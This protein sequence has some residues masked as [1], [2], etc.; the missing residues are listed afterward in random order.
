MVTAVFETNLTLQDHR[1]NIV[2]R[3]LTSWAAIIAVPT[4]VTGF[5][6]QNVEFPGE[7]AWSGLGL[8]AAVIGVTSTVLYRAFKHRDWI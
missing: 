2:I 4:L 3:K 6:G 5:F 1:L 7:G 8:S